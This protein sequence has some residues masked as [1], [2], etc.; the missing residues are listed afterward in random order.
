MLV[1]TP[2]DLPKIEPDDWLVFWEMWNQYKG[3]VS[4]VH[5]NYA[6]S[7]AQVGSTSIWT[8]LDI[9][10]KVNT[11]MTWEAP[12]FDIKHSLPNMYNAINSLSINII[13]ARLVQ[14]QIPMH[15]HSDDNVD[16]WNIRAFIHGNNPHKQW[17]FTKPNDTLGERTYI[18]MPPDTNWFMYNDLHCWHGTDFD[19]D[20]K[21]ILLQIFCIGNPSVDYLT[22][23]TKK[24]EQYTIEF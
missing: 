17:Y 8:G 9:Y 19:P 18:K 23:S 24:Y 5:M 11:P 16:C 20:N 13:R 22:S 7:P 3:T 15:S 10:K 1:F 21:K 4:K 12:F 2:I 6:L 14:S